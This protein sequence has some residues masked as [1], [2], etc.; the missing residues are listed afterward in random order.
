MKKIVLIACTLSAYVH[1][2]FADS[3]YFEVHSTMDDSNTVTQLEVKVPSDPNSD[4]LRWTQE[5]GWFFNQ[6]E[7]KQNV[8]ILFRL[9]SCLF[10]GTLNSEG[11]LLC[12]EGFVPCLPYKGYSNVAMQNAVHH[13]S[14]VTYSSCVLEV[15]KKDDNDNNNNKTYNLNLK[16][17]LGTY[18]QQNSSKS[19]LWD[20]R[21]NSYITPKGQIS[22]DPIS[23]LDNI[24]SWAYAGL[25]IKVHFWDAPVIWVETD[26]GQETLLSFF[27]KDGKLQYQ[28]SRQKCLPA[29]ITNALTGGSFSENSDRKIELQKPFDEQNALTWKRVCCAIAI[30]EPE[31]KK[32]C[33]RFGFEGRSF[34]FDLSNGVLSVEDNACYEPIIFA[35]ERNGVL[36]P[37]LL[38]KS[39]SENGYSMEGF[40]ANKSVF[41]DEEQIVCKN[42]ASYYDR[43]PCQH[44][45]WCGE[46]LTINLGDTNNKTKD[47]LN[48]AALSQ[49]ET[50]LQ[51]TVQEKQALTVQLN[52]TNTTLQAKKEKK[53]ALKT[54]LVQ[55][56]Q[57]LNEN[58]AKNEELN[59]NIQILTQQIEE[60]K[61]QLEELQQQKQTLE[62]KVK[63]QEAA[64]QQSQ[65]EIAIQRQTLQVNNVEL[66]R[67]KKVEQEHKQ[68][69]EN[70]KSNAFVNTIGKQCTRN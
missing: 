64:L 24:V 27:G 28:F 13:S 45:C 57:S 6:N 53:K 63:G 65:N 52:E 26:K 36:L 32:S 18:D 21:N 3:P 49:L 37:L 4:C 23:N 50:T 17:T 12:L 68:L 39:K 35:L 43:I 60:G 40:M 67:L 66:Q 41:V 14:E 2:A 31:D 69:Q 59:Q 5:K 29:V 33:V 70:L 55:Q 51:T 34:N 16:S 46:S 20:F 47:F 61:Q 19:V 25:T 62:D 22:E 30:E 42:E 48:K 9:K 7:C 15:T 1:C 38:A 10:K 54:K 44:F 8:L 11:Q 56:E 58:Q